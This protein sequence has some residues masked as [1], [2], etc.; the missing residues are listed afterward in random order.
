M[1]I[2][3]DIVNDW[4]AKC[5]VGTLVEYDRHD[6]S[7]RIVRTKSLAVVAGNCA[8][9]ELEGVVGRMHLQCCRTVEEPVTSKE[10]STDAIHALNE[11]IEASEG[12]L[13]H[14]IANNQE[15]V[16]TA[17]DKLNHALIRARWV[18]GTNL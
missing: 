5:P 3:Q 6:L 15:G 2:I 10:L 12:M 8:M 4:N 16:L 1:S 17:M 14:V 9:I 13:M 18:K 11:L 7:K